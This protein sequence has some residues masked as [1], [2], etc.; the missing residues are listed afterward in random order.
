[1]GEPVEA[2]CGQREE[3][4]AQSDSERVGRRQG[5]A[6]VS[7][8]GSFP[9]KLVTRV[10]AMEEEHELR[11][12]DVAKLQQQAALP[13]TD[14]GRDALLFLAASFCIE[15]LC[16]GFP[17]SIGILHQ[18]YTSTLFSSPSDASIL[19][20]TGTLLVIC[21]FFKQNIISLSSRETALTTLNPS[22]GS[23]TASVSPTLSFSAAIRVA[24]G[25]SKLSD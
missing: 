17:F 24:E 19:A 20:V 4:Y 13:P 14:H 7:N 11:D 10:S 9:P 15:T 5:A 2:V 1:M 21:I 23:C 22:Q 16:W 8:F 18:Y 3:S 25:S 12:F 6:Y